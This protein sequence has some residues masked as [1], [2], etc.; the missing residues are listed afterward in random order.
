MR[1]LGL[2]LLKSFYYSKNALWPQYRQLYV[3]GKT[4]VALCI[5]ENR[6]SL[7][8]KRNLFASIANKSINTLLVQNQ[9][10][11]GQVS[12]DIFVSCL[13]YR[14]PFRIINL[15]TRMAAMAKA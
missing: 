4:E 12:I 8:R 15:L 3:A 9:V 2:F 5:E 11:D 6:F 14:C 1:D 13:Q 10:R 7:V